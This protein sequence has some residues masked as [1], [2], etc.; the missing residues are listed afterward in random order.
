MWQSYSLVGPGK[1]K[2]SQWHIRCVI[3]PPRS[4]DGLRMSWSTDECVN[5]RIPTATYRL[6]FN[7]VFTF[8]QATQIVSYLHDLGIS[9]CY[10]SPYL[11]AS[12]QS[13]HGYDVIDHRT[14]NPEVGS[15]TDYEAF[16]AALR[17]HDMGQLLD[18]VPNHMGIGSGQNA[19]W[20]DVLENGPSSPYAT[21]FDID[22][23]PPTP[24]LSHKVLLP[25]LGEQYGRALESQ[26]LQLVYE[27]GA[28]SLVVYERT[29]LPIAPRS[30]IL[31]LTHR[32]SELEQ[33]L[34]AD[35]PDVIELESIVT[36]L[37]H[38][39]LRSDTA[40]ERVNER[41]REKEVIKGRLAAVTARN[42][43]IEQFLRQNIQ[44]FNGCKD[45]PRSFDLLDT[46]LA[47]QAY[48]LS[49]WR[50]AAEE[51]NYR[52]FFDVNDLAALRTEDP[53]VFMATHQLVLRLFAE[54][55]V[56]GFRIDHIDGLYNP[57][58]YLRCLQLACTALRHG[59]SL[60]QLGSCLHNE[61]DAGKTMSD[62]AP[63]SAK[64]EPTCYVVAEKILG[65]HEQL[66]RDW[67][68]DGT[69]GYE[70]LALLNGMFVD[71]QNERQCTE[72]YHRFAAGR[73]DFADLVYDCK[74]LIMQVALASE[75]NVLTRELHRL[76]A[77]D[78][79][80]RDFTVNSLRYALREIV[81]CFPVYR[82]YISPGG[83]SPADCAIIET[84]VLSA[85]RRN[86]AVDVSLFDYVRDVLL[87]RVP[88]TSGEHVR[89]AHLA[90]VMKFQQYT[91]PVMAKGLED[92][93]F[94]RY[95]R[96]VSLNEV[97]GSP[98]RFAVSV[99][100]F[101]EASQRRLQQWPN[102][103]LSSTTHDTKRSEDVRARINVL[104]E[105]PRLW[106]SAVARWGKLNK[107]KKTLVD[108]QL[109]PSR[110]DEYLL[111]QTLIGVWPLAPLAAETRPG[112][113]QRLQEYMRKATKEAKLHTSWINPHP[114]Y[115][116]AVEHFV[117]AVVSDRRFL[118]AFLPL[119]E[120]VAVYG[121]YNALA[122]TVLKLTA[123]GVPDIYQGNEVWDFSLVDPDNR[124]PVDY[125]HR[126]ALLAE[127]RTQLNDGDRRKLAQA[128]HT[129]WRDG[130]LKLYVTSRTLRYR[131]QHAEL[132]RSGDYVPV[133]IW[134]EAQEHACAFLR[135][136]EQTGCL[137]VV[138]R[139]LAR[140]VPN[141][142]ELPPS[143]STWKNTRL[144]L[145]DW[146]RE[147]KF[148]DLFTSET[149][150]VVEE[151]R[152]ATLPLAHIFATLPVAVLTRE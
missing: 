135:R 111:Y 103:L 146:A 143:P 3:P 109:A 6:Q 32:L 34:G 24:E 123:P 21:Y 105:I 142:S 130:R 72:I 147:W 13:M 84:A 14:L 71:G 66:P 97:G 75:L 58:Q 148:H 40:P 26:H 46:L 141:S 151:E 16:V 37:T 45:D 62:D 139:L 56:T 89:L 85:Q 136:R 7:H 79:H 51:I 100:A 102:S 60:E 128:L 122:Q 30:L 67:L 15:D 78:R 50:V 92:T 4:N 55:K 152:V 83:V 120:S 39:P 99:R 63:S 131:R 93:A 2:S 18:I 134:G 43:Q 125:Q 150:S 140:L 65:S 59:E 112:F 10:A 19:W 124:R 107:A 101:H 44:R 119:A 149:L 133:D 68:F 132:F 64:G 22:W 115:D 137:I 48:R 31:L 47:D 106:R 116:A 8:S 54:G 20:H 76:S 126:I 77:Q 114:S 108:G 121:M 70:F 52:R 28:V 53:V 23:Y 69:S 25:I 61:A 96:L 87:L 82:T 33:Q 35:H 88:P 9:D 98:D 27:A 74:K 94:Y 49:Y 80:S 12:P 57:A 95:H 29:R 110:N 129:Q 145:P 86:P 118:H 41:R 11:K 42:S 117:A 81:A 38:L 127:L 104:S 138:P 144:I 5:R 90:F 73:V 17:Q 1:A 113:I 91:G 36:A